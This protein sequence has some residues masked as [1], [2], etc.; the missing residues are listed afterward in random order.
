[1]V[2]VTLPR[3]R[4]DM[5]LPIGPIMRQQKPIL[6]ALPTPAALS[7]YPSFSPLYASPAGGSGLAK[8]DDAWSGPKI[9]LAIIENSPVNHRLPTIAHLSILGCG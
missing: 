1:M 7:P 9:A 4:A 2:D 6:L 3:A 8:A 5:K